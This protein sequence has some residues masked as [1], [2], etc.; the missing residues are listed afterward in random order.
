MITYYS[1]I[2]TPAVWFF[3]SDWT[4]FY[5][6]YGCCLVAKFC[7]TLQLHGL[8]ITRILCP[9]D[10]PG[11][12]TGMCCY[13][14]FFYRGSSWLRDQTQASHLTGILFSTEPPVKTLIAFED[15][16]VKWRSSGS[17]LVI[18]CFDFLLCSLIFKKA[19]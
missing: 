5:I 9:W 11:K 14:F 18:G 17:L 6:L 19:N 12:N 2:C 15:Q 10:F 16:I 13:F 4:P 1:Q 8:W 3:W 7:L